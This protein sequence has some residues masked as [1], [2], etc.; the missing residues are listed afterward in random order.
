MKFLGLKRIFSGLL[1][2]AS[3]G[4]AR[5]SVFEFDVSRV[6]SYKPDL[7]DYCTDEKPVEKK[8]KIVF[9]F[10]SDSVMT[11]RV[12]KSFYRIHLK[13]ILKDRNKMGEDVAI[14]GGT[15]QTH[16]YVL[17][18]GPGSFSMLQ[19][20]GWTAEFSNRELS[21][22]NSR[23]KSF[24]GKDTLQYSFRSRSICL[25]D[26]EKRE[27]DRCDYKKFDNPR[28]FVLESV[29]FNGEYFVYL[30]TIATIKA[31]SVDM[32]KNDD[33]EYVAVYSDTVKKRFVAVGPNYINIVFDTVRISLSENFLS[34]VGA[35]NG[36]S[37][38]YYSGSAVAI[39]PDILITN[40]H[41]TKYMN[42]MALYLNGKK[43]EKATLEVVDE[44]SE[45]FL[46]FAI[47][48]VQGVTLNACPISNEEPSLGA[49]ILVYG[50]PQIQYQGS[51][52]KVTKG[53]VSGKNGYRGDKSMFQID[54]AVQPGN[55]GGPIVSNG[56][57]IGLATSFLDVEDS[58]NVNFGI[59]ASKIYN[60]LQFKDIV[61]KATTSNFEKCTYMLVGSD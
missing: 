44:F 41:V 42:A 12:G 19:T 36:G 7:N 49:D 1:I 29:F 61:P 47:L 23:E 24:K 28:K 50:Y 20:Y 43:L 3:L 34:D 2:L 60:L 53:I 31:T 16:R 56:K 37:G 21:Q 8:G 9:E 52:L 6:C 14:L 15:S 35:E 25:W 33:G 51:D 59:K 13:M 5:E 4:L 32:S 10:V 54:A 18:V 40:S 58:Q 30:D 26:E 17:V 22:K 57:I 39:R 55:S 46:D 27:F 38:G 11:V 48:R 45:R